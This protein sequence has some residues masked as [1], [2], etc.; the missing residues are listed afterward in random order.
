MGGH[1]L[2]GRRGRAGARGSVGGELCVW[3]GGVWGEIVVLL[4]V[5]VLS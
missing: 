2:G 1:N 3:G 5:L 4:L